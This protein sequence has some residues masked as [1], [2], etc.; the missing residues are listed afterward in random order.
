MLDDNK[1]PI[2]SHLDEIRIRLTKSFIVVIVALIISF[3]LPKY[4]LPIL[5]KPVA[6]LDLYFTEVT[7]LFS[8]YIKICLYIALA[9]SGPYILYHIVMFIRPALKRNEKGYLY[10]MLP[11]TFILFIGGVVFCYFVLLPP[12][13]SFLHSGFPEWL[14]GNVEPIWTVT[15]YISIVTQLLFWVGVVFEIPMVMFFLSKI[16][17]LS[18]QWA[19][20]RWKW[21]VLLALLLGAIITPTPDPVNQMLVATP[22][23]LLYLLGCFMAWVA[24][25]G[26]PFRSKGAKR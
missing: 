26:L 2:L 18:P 25:A 15:S 22:I 14:G 5:M 13:L 19:W 11:S 12:G 24:R 20:K 17:V 7:G 4:I 21:A 8:S 16:G 1:K 9:I 23:L 6:G 3:P 10:T